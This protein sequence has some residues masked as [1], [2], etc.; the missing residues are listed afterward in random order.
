MPALRHEPV[1]NNAGR[2]ERQYLDDSYCSLY[3]SWRRLKST[4]PTSEEAVAAVEEKVHKN[5]SS[6]LV[7]KREDK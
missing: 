3:P 5:V 6:W 2:K 4:E 1:G 7:S